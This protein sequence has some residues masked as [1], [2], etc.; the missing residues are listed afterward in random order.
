MICVGQ[1]VDLNF[2]DDTG[3]DLSALDLSVH[4]W[5]PNMDYCQDPLGEIDSADISFPSASVM[6]I[7][8]TK[9]ILNVP[10][11][12]GKLWK[13]RISGDLTGKCWTKM[14]FEVVC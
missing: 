12:D 9:G 7:S 10:T 5:S 13:F 1:A 6:V 2:T 11:E 14:E 4:Y 3:E 8:V